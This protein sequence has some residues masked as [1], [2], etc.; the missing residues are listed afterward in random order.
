MSTKVRNKHCSALYS[1]YLAIQQMYHV[2]RNILQFS[3]EVYNYTDFD[4]DSII[5]EF[6]INRTFEKIF[7]IIFCVLKT[8]AVVNRQNLKSTMELGYL[9][10]ARVVGTAAGSEL[11]CSI[12]HNILWKPVACVTCENIFCVGCIQT[13]VNTA[14]SNSEITCPFHCT[15]KEKRAPPILNGLLSKLQIYCVYRNN[16]CQEKLNY[17][18]LESHEKTCEYECASCPLCQMLLS[19]RDL[20]NNKHEIRQCFAHIQEMKIDN[21]IQAHLMILLNIIDEQNKQI[22]A[23]EDQLNQTKESKNNGIDSSSYEAE[24]DRTE[25]TSFKRS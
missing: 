1:V 3:F 21:Q 2:E 7:E 11:L 22:K 12:C 13:W 18:A 19:R 25:P 16:G 5:A 6:S 17:D 15:F 9:D 20:T 23:L 24:P 14:N 4:T 8:Q 10:P